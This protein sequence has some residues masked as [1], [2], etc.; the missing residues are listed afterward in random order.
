M[1][2]LKQIPRE[3][4]AAAVDKAL[5]YRLLNEPLEAE[6]ICR[7]VL[8][9]EPDNQEALVTLLLSLT[10]QFGNEFNVALDEAKHVVPLLETEYQRA[11]YEGII[12]ER[13]GKAEHGRGMPGQVALG[14]VRAAL[15]SFERARRLASEGDPDAILRW[16]A[17]VR[18]LEQ[19]Q[20]EET[21]E[22]E[23]VTREMAFEFDE[24][25]PPR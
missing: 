2:E 1:L 19:H 8:R 3:S 15:R 13:W 24:E 20:Q 16:N 10:D 18:F 21:S 23:V 14:W 17:C 11:Y 7:D 5:R 6:S 4:V 12:Y 9:I 22:Y 25:M